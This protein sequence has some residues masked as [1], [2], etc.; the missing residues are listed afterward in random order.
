MTKPLLTIEF[1]IALVVFF[2]SVRVMLWKLF[3]RSAIRSFV[4][5]LTSRFLVGLILRSGTHVFTALV[6]TVCKLLIDCDA[7]SVSKLFL[8]MFSL[9]YWS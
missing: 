9:T 5:S 3:R 8:L 2:C 6:R 7:F 1:D 4:L